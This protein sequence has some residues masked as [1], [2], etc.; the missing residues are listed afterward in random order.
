[1]KNSQEIILKKSFV[2][3]KI[4]ATQFDSR[5]KIISRKDD[6][7]EIF[8]TNVTAEMS[9]IIY[10]KI[11]VSSF[12]RIEEARKI[13]Y[14]TEAD[15]EKIFQHLFKENSFVPKGREKLFEAGLKYGLKGDW[16]CCSH[17]LIPHLKTQLE[18]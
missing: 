6:E 1:M 5:D 10:T 16:L 14:E 2:L 18:L 8:E 4:P 3:S 12:S 17:I 7:G 11:T 15:N 13:L 9:R